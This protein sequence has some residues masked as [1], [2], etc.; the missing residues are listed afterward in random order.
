MAE[1]AVAVAAARKQTAAQLSAIAE[2]AADGFPGA[3]IGVRG[4]VEDWLDDAPALAVEDR[5]R[6][7]LARSREK[8]AQ[9]GGAAVGPHRSDLSV[10]H[11]AHGRPAEVCSTG[12]QKMLLIGVVLAGARLQRRERGVGPLLLLDEV[13][14]HLDERHRRAVFDAVGDLTAQ[15]W[16]AGCDPTPFRPLGAMAQVVCL[17]APAGDARSA[18]GASMP[19]H[20]TGIDR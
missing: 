13:I 10:V 17:N 1:H 5:L 18:T 7:E 4:A 11:L 16:Y 12:E 8:D 9:S 14:A 2:D 3:V 6:A 15:T 20:P 19:E